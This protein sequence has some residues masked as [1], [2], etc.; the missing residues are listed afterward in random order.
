MMG[1]NGGPIIIKGDGTPI[2]SYL[3]T[4]DLAIWLWTILFKGQSCRPYNVGSDELISIA[5]LA[6][7]VA[8]QFSTKIMVETRGQAGIGKLGER[9]VPNTQRIRQELGV[10]LEISLSA[11]ILKRSNITRSNT[12]NNLF[13]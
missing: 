12:L 9:Y 6:H 1:L 4:S 8:G 2:R 5:E 10:T 13:Y 3:Y 7:H 11:G